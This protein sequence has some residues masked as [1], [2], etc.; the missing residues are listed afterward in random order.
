VDEIGGEGEEVGRDEERRFK[1]K[2]PS[3]LITNIILF[4]DKYINFAK[5]YLISIQFFKPIYTNFNPLELFFMEIK[6]V[7]NL[8]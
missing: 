8:K 7:R 2:N 5:F 3:N 6:L 1:N 4:I